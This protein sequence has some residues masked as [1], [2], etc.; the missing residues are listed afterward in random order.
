MR[1]FFSN[2]SIVALLGVALYL[3]VEKDGSPRADCPD[4]AFV[5]IS[6]T[7]MIA[8]GSYRI[9]VK[10]RNNGSCV[11][12]KGTVKLYAVMKS[13]PGDAQWTESIKRKFGLVDDFPGYVITQDI[14]VNATATF[15][16]LVDA[17]PSKGDYRIRYQ[18]IKKPGVVD[19]FG[20]YKEV[21]FQVKPNK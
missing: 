7:T 2:I 12:K 5:S 1:T 18:L 3:P 10:F 17:F 13:I 14:P 19:Y 6:S 11:W 9:T 4:S 8:G 15:T 20:A 21:V 16:F